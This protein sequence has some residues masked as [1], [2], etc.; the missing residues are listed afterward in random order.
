MDQTRTF[1]PLP[2]DIAGPDEL[3]P[4]VERANG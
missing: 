4:L 3:R 2:A 1:L